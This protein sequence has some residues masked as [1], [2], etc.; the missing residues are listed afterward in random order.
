MKIINELDRLMVTVILAS[1]MAAGFMGKNAIVLSL[2]RIEGK[3]FLP[4]NLI[5]L[6]RQ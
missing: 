2:G 6:E 5:S 4:I 3:A 1:L